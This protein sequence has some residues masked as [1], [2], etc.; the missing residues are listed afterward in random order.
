MNGNLLYNMIIGL[1]PLA[2]QKTIVEKVEKLMQ[3]VSLMEKEIQ[4]SKQ[5]AKC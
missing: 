2:E 3:K 5:N 4:K 1:P